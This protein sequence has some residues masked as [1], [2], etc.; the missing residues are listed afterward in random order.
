MIPLF[1]H[2]QCFQATIPVRLSLS[3][4]ICSHV[5]FSLVAFHFKNGCVLAGDSAA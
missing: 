5:A 3:V 2:P 4:T 1:Q